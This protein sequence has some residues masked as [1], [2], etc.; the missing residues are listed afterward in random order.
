MT[1]IS[2]ASGWNALPSTLVEDV[3]FTANITFSVGV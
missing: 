1:T 3:T 2:S